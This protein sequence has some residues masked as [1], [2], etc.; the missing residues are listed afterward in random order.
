MP[1]RPTQVHELPAVAEVPGRLL[2]LHAEHPARYPAILDS[3]ATGG[4]L[5]RY[6]LLFAAPG[7][8]LTL[9]RSGRLTGP[10]DGDRFCTRLSRWWRDEQGAAP[11]ESWPFA[12]GWFLY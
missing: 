9:G 2:S 6:S 11:P 8:R 4:S 3:A 12:G 10:G 5:G 1:R 7:D